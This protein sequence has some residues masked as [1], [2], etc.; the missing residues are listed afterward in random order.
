MIIIPCTDRKRQVPGPKLLARN[1]PQGSIDNVAQNWAKIINS[2]SHSFNANQIYC[3]RPFAEALKAAN[4]CQ[5]KLVVVS[6]GLGLVDMYSKIP[7]YGLTVAE[8]HSDSVSNLVTIDS[9]GPSM[10]WASLKKTNV[11]TFDFSD[12]FEK[13]NPSLILVHLTRQYARMVY[14]EL[15]C[16]SSDKVSKIRLFGLGLEEFIPQSLVEC[17]MPYDHRMNG[18][19]SSNRG[20]ITDFGARSIWHFVQLL[21]NKELETGSLSQHKKLAEGAL[22]HWK[23][24]VKPNRQ[25]LTDEQVIDFI[26]RNWSAVSGGSQKML[27]LLRSSGNA[28][29]QAR[30]KNLFHEAKKKS[31]V[32]LGLPL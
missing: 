12:Y 9:W 4:A 11:G 7:T 17:L 22:S 3:G 23:M 8:R 26:T 31:Q 2:S 21:K 24:P 28:C 1:L 10:W 14:D 32:Q 27:K 20:T 6:A 30:F 29:E 25:R 13:N 15:A 16:L 5:A 18:P 19:D